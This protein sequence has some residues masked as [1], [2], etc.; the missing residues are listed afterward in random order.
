MTSN[1]MGKDKHK[2]GETAATSETNP[3]DGCQDSQ[4]DHS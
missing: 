2:D 4:R 3:Q 1:K